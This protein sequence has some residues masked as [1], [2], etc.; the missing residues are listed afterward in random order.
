MGRGSL[1]NRTN[2]DIVKGNFHPYLRVGEIVR[3]S[4]TEERIGEVLEYISGDHF[5]EV[6]VAFI[7]EAPV[8]R[9]ALALF[10]ATETQERA[11][12]ETKARQQLASC[13][14]A[15]QVAVATS[16]SSTETCISSQP[17][18]C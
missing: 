1:F 13:R 10:P 5:G 11:Y 8:R 15:A 4:G 7:G 6:T 16:L 17:E 2:E 18:T 9:P 3:T 14:A 12:L